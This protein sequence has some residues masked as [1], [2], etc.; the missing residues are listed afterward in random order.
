MILGA[1]GMPA[2]SASQ[3]A[4]RTAA[5]T[6]ALREGVKRFAKEP[7]VIRYLYRA[8]SN[9]GSSIVCIEISLGT[10]GS[11]K[12]HRTNYLTCRQLR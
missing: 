12:Y 5:R 9:P 1:K 11:H 8:S 3:S 2:I 4:A 7:I 10:T 6:E